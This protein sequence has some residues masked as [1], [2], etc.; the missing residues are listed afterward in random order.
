L[1]SA[2]LK[3]SVLAIFRNDCIGIVLEMGQ[4]EKKC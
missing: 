4:R 3:Y 2:K 1:L